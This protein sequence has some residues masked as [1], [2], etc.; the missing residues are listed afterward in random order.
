MKRTHRNT[1]FKAF[2]I[3]A[4][5]ISGATSVLANDWPT[6]LYD[7]RRSGT[8]PEQLRLPLVEEWNHKTVPPAPAWTESPAFDGQTQPN[9]KPRQNFDL[10]FDVVVAGHLA[11]FG[12]SNTGA[13]RCLDVHTGKIVWTFVTDG[14]IRLAPQLAHGRVY[15]GSDDGY[16]YCLDG[17]N[18]ALLW[19]DRAGPDDR[20]LWGNGRLISVWPVRSS[21]LVDG[22]SVFWSAGLFPREGMYLCKRNA[23][24]GTGGWTKPANRPSQGYLVAGANT[25]YV[26]GGKGYPVTYDRHTGDPL[27]AIKA[28]GRDGG[29]W[30]L[31]SPDE[32][33]FW[34]G[35]FE[36]N[37]AYQ[38]DAQT[39]G[40]LASVANANSMIV[41]STHAYYVTDKL[42]VKIKL[43]DQS[44]VWHSKHA[45][46]HALIK[47][48]DTLYVGGESEIAAF[49]NLGNR[50][51]TAPVDGT[52]CGL[53]AA[54]G[55]L[56]ASTD[57]GT[58]HCFGNGKPISPPTE[59]VLRNP[60]ETHVRAIHYQGMAQEVLRQVGISRGT[61]LILGCDN[62]HFAYEIAKQ[63]KDLQVHCISHD[64]EQVN[65]AQRNLSAAGVY[66]TRVHVEQGD[67]TSLPYSA[68]FADLILLPD[69]TRLSSDSEAEKKELMEKYRN[70]SAEERKELIQQAQT[71]YGQF[72][73]QVCAQAL[74]V[75]KPSGGVLYVDLTAQS[76]SLSV[77]PETL[78]DWM[79]QP[80][81]DPQ[82]DTIE[83]TNTW[84]KLTR[85]E[86]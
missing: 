66:K 11:Y 74:R 33:R 30:A 57:N 12:S 10:C 36:K 52:A 64:S 1:A 56:F 41:D 58:I 15:V 77:D 5:S 44:V 25:L 45:Y 72:F 19:K 76:R 29:A 62:G 13:V 55:Q 35:P 20:M 4:I 75:L 73:K 27:G 38:F 37:A 60:Y 21:I 83:A 22:N 67:F 54:N 69:A 61:C 40:H 49:D 48:G 85:V 18:G 43:A 68:S 65:T 42:L 63:A 14:P 3:L 47:A 8:T 51:W 70:A 50:I 71:K 53:A 28:S 80:P 78:R 39:R 81:F 6:R 24:D 2:L 34:S 86:Q 84:I 46:A 32:S 7:I 31:L 16:A 79:S 9:L 26:P 23:L 82:R 59:K 17:A